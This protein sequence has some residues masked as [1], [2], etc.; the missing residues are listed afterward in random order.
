[1]MAMGMINWQR[2][3]TEW[4]GLRLVIEARSDHWI[5]F[6]YDPIQVR[7]A[8]HSGTNESGSCQIL[9]LS[10]TP[11]PTGLV[12][13]TISSQRLSRLCSSGIPAKKAR[14]LIRLTT[15]HALWRIDLWNWV[16]P[17]RRASA[18][19]I[20]D[21]GCKTGLLNNWLASIFQKFS[22]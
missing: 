6:V 22:P 18:R 20:K 15:S 21:F 11:Q 10:N 14:K 9:V 16:F 7:S 1:M 13:V 2:Y 17:L 5:V 8:L 19:Q 3:Q 4:E 12:H